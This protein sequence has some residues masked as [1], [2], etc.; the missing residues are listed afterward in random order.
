MGMML[1]DQVHLVEKAQNF[2]HVPSSLL[3]RLICGSFA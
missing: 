1:N 2:E 3:K